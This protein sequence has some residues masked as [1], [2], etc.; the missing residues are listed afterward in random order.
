MPGVKVASLIE[1]K[2]KWTKYAGG[3]IS[4]NERFNAWS[5]LSLE[6]TPYAVAAIQYEGDND[7]SNYLVGR[8]GIYNLVDDY[9][10]KDMCFVGRRMI[11]SQGHETPYLDE[12]E[13]V[14]DKSAIKD[15]T[16]FKEWNLT[17]DEFINRRVQE[18]ETLVDINNVVSI[19]DD[20]GI[21]RL[22]NN[23]THSIIPALG[24]YED[25]V[26]NPEYNT[27]Y[28]FKNKDGSISY[29]IF[30]I[31]NY[32]YNVTFYDEE[33]TILLADVPIHGMINYRGDLIRQKY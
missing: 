12:W 16:D 5:A 32:W 19:A 26:K 25:T 27:V 6:V 30:Y 18:T 20:Q 15:K 17:W 31:D 3:T 21:N 2:H 29:K 24:G 10:V 11:R 23:A 9:P 4:M 13:F 33:Q 8:T 22:W 7:F 14:L 1:Q 28:G